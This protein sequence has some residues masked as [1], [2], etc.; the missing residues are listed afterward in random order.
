MSKKNN[1]ELKKLKKEIKNIEKGK[2][3]KYNNLEKLWKYLGI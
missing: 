1:K 3:K 2:G